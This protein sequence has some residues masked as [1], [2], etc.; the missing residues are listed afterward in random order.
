MVPKTRQRPLR[1]RARR[2]D[3]CAGGRGPRDIFRGRRLRGR[4]GVVNKAAD[5]DAAR[6]SADDFLAETRRLEEDFTPAAPPRCALPADASVVDRR[7]RLF[8]TVA[9][10]WSR[11]KA[12][13]ARRAARTSGAPQEQE[14]HHAKGRGV[15][16]RRGPR[17]RRGAGDRHLR[18]R[19][20]PEPRRLAAE[21]RLVP[22]ATSRSGAA[23]TALATRSTRATATC[24]STS[25]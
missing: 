2:A 18:L 15:R 24:N 17:R 21:G 19:G 22:K 9:S 20:R 5:G 25:N 11:S 13:S 4:V 6:Q 8:R 16:R 1:A 23:R 12:T 3:R 7:P 10:Y 14:P